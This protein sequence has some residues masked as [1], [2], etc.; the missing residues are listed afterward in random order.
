MSFN[1]F[2]GTTKDPKNLNEAEENLNVI[3]RNVVNKQNKDTRKNVKG[4]GLWN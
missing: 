4:G 2:K 1:I 3:K